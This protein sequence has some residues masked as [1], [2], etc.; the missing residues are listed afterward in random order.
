MMEKYADLQRELVNSLTERLLD[1]E[2]EL[3]KKNFFIIDPAVDHVLFDILN[4]HRSKRTA[5]SETISDFLYETK[6][7]REAFD[8]RV[9]ECV[10]DKLYAALGGL[11]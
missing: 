7:K 6:L 8:R 10:Y 5:F 9:R 1:I 11:S 3:G 4:D 2:Y